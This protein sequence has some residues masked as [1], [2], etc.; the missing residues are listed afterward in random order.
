MAVP[1]VTVGGKMSSLLECAHRPLREGE[2]P[3]RKGQNTVYEATGNLSEDG[4][5]LW[6]QAGEGKPLA[7]RATIKHDGQC[8][9]I[10][11]DQSTN[12]WTLSLYR[13]LDVK[14]GGSVPAYAIKLPSP[15][16]IFHDGENADHNIHWVKVD[17][18]GLAD[19]QYFESTL[20]RDKDGRVISL[21]M[22]VPRGQHHSYERVPVNSLPSDATV[23]LIGPKVQSDPYGISKTPYGASIKLSI[24]DK[25]KSVPQHWLILHGTFTMPLPMSWWPMPTLASVTSFILDKKIEGLVFQFRNG[26]GELVAMLKVN[27]GHIGVPHEGPHALQFSEMGEIPSLNDEKDSNKKD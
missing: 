26:K 25:M 3:K 16:N 10:L 4:I 2:T 15:A 24:G 17:G 5:K 19:N 23:E 1:H 18:S 14:E 27:R 6:D 12:P 9:R 11:V 20:I 22:I 13:R 7:V 8:S 21:A